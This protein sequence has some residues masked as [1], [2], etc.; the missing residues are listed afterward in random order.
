MKL[1]KNHIEI[2]FFDFSIKHDEVTTILELNP[3]HSWMKD[4]EYFVGPKKTKKIRTENF[5]GHEVYTETNE[6][7]GDQVGEFLKSIVAPRKA[8]IKELTDRFHGEFSI[9]QYLYD[10]CNPGTLF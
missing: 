6:F 8:Q 10:G 5:W 1:N 4:E 9:I 3:T 7:I 2:K